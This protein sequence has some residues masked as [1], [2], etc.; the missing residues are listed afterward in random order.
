MKKT[1]LVSYNSPECLIIADYSIYE[2]ELVTV[3]FWGL[4]KTTN[5]VEYKV[6]YH[7]STKACFEHWDKLIAN[8]TPF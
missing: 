5:K 8:K 7:Q 4:F 6:H 1:Y 3:W 2:L